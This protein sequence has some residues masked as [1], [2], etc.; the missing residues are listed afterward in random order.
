[1][2]DGDSFGDRHPLIATVLL[3]AFLFFAFTPVAV[4]GLRLYH[5]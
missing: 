5:G 1:M 2:D 4:M 3:I